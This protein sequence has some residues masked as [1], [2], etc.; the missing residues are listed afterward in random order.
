MTG[1]VTHKLLEA[2]GYIK[3]N[4]LLPSG[5]DKTTAD[6]MIAVWG[7]ALSDANFTGGSDNV[8]Y[9]VNTAG[10]NGPFKVTVNLYYQSLAYS[11]IKALL[12]YDTA[13]V[14]SFKAIY[15]ASNKAPVL[16]GSITR[17]IQ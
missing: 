16:V 14:Q 6:D 7:D 4:R 17:T 8:T 10:F 1:G 11:S 5:F 9:Q 3:D 15:N 13:E 12:E 2:S